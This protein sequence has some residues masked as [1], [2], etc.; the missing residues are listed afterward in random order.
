MSDLSN[1][2]RYI[3]AIKTHYISARIIDIWVNLRHDSSCIPYIILNNEDSVYSHYI[4]HC[5]PGMIDYVI[6]FDTNILSS[7]SLPIVPC[8]PRWRNSH[9]N[10]D[11]GFYLLSKLGYL[12][13]VSQETMI[14][15]IDHDVGLCGLSWPAFFEILLN[16]KADAYT[17]GYKLS[18]ESW[19]HFKS[20]KRYYRAVYNT[21]FGVQGIRKHLVEHLYTQRVLLAQKVNNICLSEIGKDINNLNRA[22]ANE[23]SP[24]CEGFFASELYQANINVYDII[25]FHNFFWHHFQLDKDKWHHPLGTHSSSNHKFFLYHPIKEPCYNYYVEPT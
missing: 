13:D 12:D 9:R 7:L 3:V 25:K 11:Y 22:E 8:M 18:P 23:Y 19:A 17:L 16:S 21:L 2:N 10:S 5:L 4:K 6:P 14:F 15:Q 1:H 20:C 24:I